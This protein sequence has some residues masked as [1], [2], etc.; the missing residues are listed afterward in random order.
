MHAV[1]RNLV[2]LFIATVTM[3]LSAVLDV[4]LVSIFKSNVGW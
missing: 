1:L 4:S 2:N 3:L